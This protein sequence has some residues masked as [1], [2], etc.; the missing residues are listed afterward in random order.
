MR[1]AQALFQE[2]IIA[3]RERKDIREGRRL[4]MES[5][6]ANPDNDM[7]WLWLARTV[8]NPDKRLE[9]VERA[10]ALNPDNL[11]A[12]EMKNR[13]TA[14]SL[15]GHGG[16]KTVEQ[17]L[18]P[19][20]QK[21]IATLM[22]QAE[23]HIVGDDA[24]AAIE[25]WVRVL[26]IQVDHEEALRLAVSQLGRLKYMDDAREL[27]M[28]AIDAGTK[29]PSIYLTAIDIARYQGEAHEADALRERLV[30]LPGTSDDLIVRI[31]NG[32]I[33]SEQM[34]RARDLL[35]EALEASPDSQH[36]LTALGD[37]HRLM[38]E[39]TEATRYYE[40]AARRGGRE[41]DK[42]LLDY[43]PI[44]T[45]SERGS[46]LLAWREAAGIA[47]FCLFLAWQDAGLDLLRLGPSRWLGV[48]LGLVGGYLVVTATSSP[49][50]QPIAR[51]LQGQIPDF[52]D[53]NK[54]AKAGVIEEDTALLIIP[55]QARMVVGIVGG[56]LVLLALYLVF[57]TAFQLLLNPVTP[58]DL[59]TLNELLLE[60]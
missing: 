48:A 58:P 35:L 36:I 40:R 41:A 15:N 22:K 20:E 23:Q 42:K 46:Q 56:V 51:L 37:V 57:N 45:D 49:Q 25:A 16:M 34:M 28:R 43:A 33:E 53:R 13:L 38:G 12:L 21:R 55:T 39:E 26:E 2:G 54:D 3:L 8:S 29:H 19:A 31:A 10:L 9:F 52:S 59:P 17:P 11:R 14:P 50:Q 4:L 30:R 5:L 24:E 7:A 60:E 47:I 32:F 18:S 6:R 44:I 27:V 1:E